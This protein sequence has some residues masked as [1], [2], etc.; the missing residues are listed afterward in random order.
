VSGPD[1]AVQALF[2]RATRHHAAGQL[3]EA[4]QG[5]REALA[6]APDHADALHGYGVLAHQLGRADVAVGMIGRALKL[7]GGRAHYYINLGRALRDLGHREEA[8]GAFQCAVI[9]DPDDPVA[10]FNVAVAL[11]E[12]GRGAEAV[13]HY[14]AAVRLDPGMAEA[15][16]NLGVL[17]HTAGEVTEAGACFRR[18]AALRP[19]DA[20]ARGLWALVLREQG[21][22]VEAESVLREA[23]R[24]DPDNPEYRNMLGATLIDLGRQAEA[25]VELRR[26]LGAAPEHV[27]ARNNLGLALQGL[28]RLEEAFT[29]LQT[30]VQR[31]PDSP[32]ILSNLGGVLRDLGRAEEAEVTWRK[33]LARDPSHASAHFN[34]GAVLLARGDFAAG[35]AK[36]EWRDR[37][38]GR[39]PREFTQPRWRGEELGGGVLL[40]H[41]EQGFGDAIQFCRYVPMAA[42]RGRIVLEMP[43]PLVRLMQ[44]LS[45]VDRVIAQGG[46]LPRIDVHCPMLSLPHVFGT[47]VE[48]I[49][50]D[51]PYVQAPESAL[52]KSR[53]GGLAG[54]R[55]GLCWAGSAGYRYDRWRSLTSGELV[56]LAG[57][58]EVSLVSLQKDPG[59][60][61]PPEL[62]LHDWSAELRDFADTAALIAELDLVISVDTAV[63]HLAG[64][65]GKPVWLLNRF[66]P[67]WRWMQGGERSLWYPSLRQFRQPARDDWG[68]VMTAAAR[69][70]AA[71]ASE[72]FDGL[73]QR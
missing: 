37:V 63:A 12:L 7:G 10:Q 57:V 53:V 59:H 64:A 49:P 65:L 44:G 50:A 4:E 3:A 13:E 24:L 36:F 1:S 41:A 28:G 15:W 9:L 51:V 73:G 6:I 45:G 19:G 60:S 61:V 67:D 8:R 69:A 72:R 48:T 46:A 58:P 25:E 56:A 32:D 2:E 40:I 70:L 29:E 14:R 21:R 11:A 55:V 62:K 38:P 18:V 34:L 5:Y 42:R 33:V 66:D 47:T 30:A 54:L 20:A 26:A 68:S 52:W 22:A 35:W 39:R 31:Q 16:V 27:Q 43:G 23:V 71:E 17:L